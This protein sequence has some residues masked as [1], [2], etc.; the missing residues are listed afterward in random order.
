MFDWWWAINCIDK[1][2]DTVGGLYLPPPA[3]RTLVCT[4]RHWTGIIL[5]LGLI[6]SF[7][8]QASEFWDGKSMNYL[9]PPASLRHIGS[10]VWLSPTGHLFGHWERTRSILLTC[11]GT[12]W[13]IWCC[14]AIT[15][16]DLMAHGADSGSFDGGRY[17]SAT[18]RDVDTAGPLADMGPMK[19]QMWCGNPKNNKPCHRGV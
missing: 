14:K 13:Q 18:A 11:L 7:S 17:C 12:E 6:C 1:F 8:S 15:S 9:K 4:S 5:W 10:W 3:R 16:H 2:V 19:M